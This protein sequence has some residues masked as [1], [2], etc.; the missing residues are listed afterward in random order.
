MLAAADEL[1]FEYAAQLRDELRELR[2]DL[3]EI[4]SPESSASGEILRGSETSD[5]RHGLGCPPWTSTGRQSN[6]GTSRS[7]GAGTTRPRWTRTCGRSPTEFEELQRAAITGGARRVA[8]LDRRQRRCRASSQAAETAAAEIER[9]ALENARAGARGGRP[10]RRRAP[11]RRRSSRRAR[12][13]RRSRRSTATLLER[14]GS[15]DGEVSA[16]VESLRAGAGRLAADLAAVETRHGRALRR[17]LRTR[18]RAP[19]SA[20]PPRQLETPSRPSSSSP[21]RSGRSRRS[22]DSALERGAASPWPR[23]QPAQPRGGRRGRRRSRRRPPDRAEHGAQRR[24]ARGHRALPR[25]ELPA[26]PTG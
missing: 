19:P 13:S 6:A 1:R 11:A 2:R 25:R 21:S 5:R 4:Q 26:S 17:G 3:Q 9:Q 12:T 14:V 23:R 24:V 18:H 10:R 7:A 22:C 20:E 16:L 15:M 8:R